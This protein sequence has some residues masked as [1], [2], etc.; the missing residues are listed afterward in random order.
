MGSIHFRTRALTLV[1]AVMGCLCGAVPAAAATF[2]VNRTLDAVDA[3]PGDGICETAPGN[4]I[5][6]LR[7]AIQEANTRPG[8]DVINLPAGTYTLTLQNGLHEDRAVDG[9][10]DVTD[11]LTLVGAGVGRTIITAPR[12]APD[13]TERVLHLLGPIS[14]TIRGVTIRG[15]F[16]LN[17]ADGGCIHNVDAT[18][19]ITQSELTSGTVDGRGGGLYNERGSVTI[20]E[21]LLVRNFAELGGGGGIANVAGTV[22]VTDST[23]NNNGTS[24]GDGAGVANFQGTMMI[25]NS[26]IADNNASE[27]VGGGLSNERGL[28]IV[29]NTTFTG[30]RSGT[31][32]GFAA[33]GNIVNGE[34][35]ITLANVTIARNGNLGLVFPG[36]AR[37]GG[38]LNRNG[39]I[40]LHNSLLAHNVA[41]EGPDCSG[42]ITSLGYN[43]VGNLAGCTFVR[44]P[45]DNVGD[46]RLGDFVP[47][48]TPG[49]G[50]IPLLAG[51][52]AIDRGLSAT[53]GAVDQLNQPRRDGNAIGGTQCD[54]GAVEFQP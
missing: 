42:V 23:I 41:Q 50:H 14:V 16:F 48:T 53:C 33:G 39:R 43:I 24:D 29:T 44:G 28:V 1:A 4:R 17:G 25:V 7:A 5:C 46:P 34:G 13:D 15:G 10:L 40:T 11:S 8:A 6:T 27:S 19:T 12:T 35:T 9:D 54:R 18:L 36:L 49:R 2:T 3:R 20:K 22:I 47:S 45:A 30:N 37:G 51:S 31:G 32:D 38:L 52:A 26:T 21:S